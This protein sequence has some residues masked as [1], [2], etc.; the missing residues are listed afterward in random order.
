ML[1]RSSVAED[2]LKALASYL[3]ERW[4]TVVQKLA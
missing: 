2:S 4:R 1:K 3:L